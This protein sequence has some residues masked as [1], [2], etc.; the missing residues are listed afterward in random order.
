MQADKR[1]AAYNMIPNL[2]WTIL[3]LG[4]AFLFSYN[5]LPLT[6]ALI[7]LGSSLIPTFFPNKF[8]D[9]IQLSRSPCFYERL[10][11]KHINNFA[12]NG[13]LI[14]KFLRRKYPEFKNVRATRSSIVKRYKETY[15]FEKFHFSLFIFYIVITIYSLITAHLLWTGILSLCNLL[16]NIYPNLLQQYVRVKLSSAHSR[17]STQKNP[18]PPPIT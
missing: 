3:F 13:A 6:P 12:Q 17:I 8:F 11:V 16:Y 4:P 1:S 2:V 10:G 5:Y 15:F 7:L 14:N 9:T 18:P